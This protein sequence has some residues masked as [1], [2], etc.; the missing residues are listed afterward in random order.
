MTLW[1]SLA[2]PGAEREDRASRAVRFARVAGAP[3]VN[4][5]KRCGLDPLGSGQE[6]AELVMDLLRVV[7]ARE[8]EALGDAR[9]VRIHGQGRY[10]E[11][12]AEHDIG[13]LPAHPGQLHE[14]FERARDLSAM[15]LD[16][17][18]AHA[19]EGASLGLEEPRGVNLLLEGRRLR[20]RPVFGLAVALEE[21]ARHGV[22]ALIGALG[23]ENGGDKQL[24]GIAEAELDTGRRIGAGQPRQYPRGPRGSR[25]SAGLPDRGAAGMARAPRAT[26]APGALGRPRGGAR[27]ASGYAARGS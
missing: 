10:A 7:R 23:R 19:H 15:P 12:I 5:Q 21:R 27:G 11:G 18:P 6:S 16:Q 20:A 9:H 4:D 3:A 14:L 25:R 13:R 26:P 1:P 8:S 22:H 2:G 17:G 24:E